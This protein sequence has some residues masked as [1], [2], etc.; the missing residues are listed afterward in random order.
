MNDNKNEILT[1]LLFAKAAYGLTPEETQQL[2]ELEADVNDTSIEMTLA[3][4][5]AAHFSDK[6]EAMPEALRSKILAG[7][8]QFFGAEADDRTTDLQPTFTL[9]PPARTPLTSWLGWAV[10]ALAVAA[11]TT[12]L[13]LTQFRPEPQVAG[14]PPIEQTKPKTPTEMRNELMSSAPDLEKAT[15]SAGKMPDVS[16]VS[17]D[18]I[19][20]D[21]QQA[22]YMRL[23]GLP[24]N[25]PKKEQYQLWIY[26]ENQGEKTPIDGGVFDVAENGEIIIPIDAK[27]QAKNPKMFAITIEKPGGV[28]VSKG[29]KVAAIAKPDLNPET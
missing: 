28:V 18:V 29:E 21:K 20:S 15:W 24:A 26:E 5:S 19:W 11:L 3:A 14:N 13:Y 10:A 22:G 6:P 1:D 27:L 16:G 25:D 8:D 12:N 9:E 7:A 23:K 2:A 17:G 4:F